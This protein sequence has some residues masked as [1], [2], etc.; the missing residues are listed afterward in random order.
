[1]NDTTIDTPST[2]TVRRGLTQPLYKHIV[3]SV[4]ARANCQKTGNTEWELKHAETLET[5]ARECLPSGSGIDNGTQID[6][7]ASTEDKIVLTTAFHHMDDGGYYDGWTDHTVTVTA[8]LL[9]TISLKISG[10]NRN[11]IK[12]YLYDVFLCEL[13]REYCHTYDSETKRIEFELVRDE[14]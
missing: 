1:M 3:S 5:I 4:V 10:R 11:E 7:D 2:P 14:D 13:M 9:S 12:D 8:D 6:L